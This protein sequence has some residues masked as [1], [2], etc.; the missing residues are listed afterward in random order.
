M[1]NVKDDF[2]ARTKEIDDYFDFVKTALSSKSDFSFVD[3]NDAESSLK[4]TPNLQKILKANGFLL[5]YNLVESTM[6]NAIEAIIDHLKG[7]KTSFD[8]LSTKVKLIILKNTKNCSP[9]TLEASIKSIAYDLIHNTF[10]KDDLFSGN[11]D[12]RKIRQTMNEYGVSYNVKVDGA[13]LLHIKTKRN[14]LAHGTVSF[15]DCGKDY[16]INDLIDFKDRTKSYLEDV[17]IGIENFLKNGDY[18]K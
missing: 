7:Q 10:K 6:S 14:D 9:E 12:A 11:I 8:D 2:D 3:D 15:T 17:V 1:Q 4:I 16:D 5:L 13:C 18:K